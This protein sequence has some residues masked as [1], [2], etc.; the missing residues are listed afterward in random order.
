[1]ALASMTR[2]SMWRRTQPCSSY[3]NPY[4]DR[5]NPNKACIPTPM[6]GAI[7]SRE[8]YQPEKRSFT[9]ER[10]FSVQ[11]ARSVTHTWASRMDVPSYCMCDRIAGKPVTV[12]RPY[13]TQSVNPVCGPTRH[14]RMPTHF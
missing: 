6:P 12:V 2:W 14:T 1:M 3:T 5:L 4:K 8:E 13:L 9:L 11:P 7:G 10:E